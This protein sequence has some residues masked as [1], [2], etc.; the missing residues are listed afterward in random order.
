MNEGAWLV[1][2]GVVATALGAT[3]ALLVQGIWWIGAL[4]GLA[5]YLVILLII[6]TSGS[7]PNVFFFDFD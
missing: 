3:V 2:W 7:S 4:I 6:Y 5:V 1:F